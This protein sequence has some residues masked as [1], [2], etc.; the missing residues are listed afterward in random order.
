MKLIKTLIVFLLLSGVAYGQA[1]LEV[2]RVVTST[3]TIDTSAYA[4]GDNIGGQLTFTGAFV[5]PGYGGEITAVL[6]DEGGEA[7]NVELLL[8]YDNPSASTFTDQ[9]AQA[10][11][12]AD[13]DKICG[14]IIFNQHS[15][16]SNNG[17]SQA[18]GLPPRCF[19]KTGSTSLYGA[20][21]ARDAV[22]YDATDALK[23]I[24]TIKK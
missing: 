5:E 4:S 22:T 20:L 21:I 24:L 19:S 14:S 18:G 12:D 17:F 23:V 2:A 7:K 15:A 9:A 6:A 3:P 1:T 10:I 11:A 16:L 8:F 13:L